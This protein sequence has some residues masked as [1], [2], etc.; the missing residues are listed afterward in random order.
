M[1]VWAG[2]RLASPAQCRRQP[3][4]PAAADCRGNF[5]ALQAGTPHGQGAKLVLPMAL[6]RIK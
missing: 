6:K 2:A 5:S 1:P 4:T 3:S